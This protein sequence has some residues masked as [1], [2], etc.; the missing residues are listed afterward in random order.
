ME[1]AGSGWAHGNLQ[2]AACELQWYP[3]PA[4]QSRQERLTKWQRDGGTVY[5]TVL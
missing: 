3:H 1:S 4:A 2:P 5:A